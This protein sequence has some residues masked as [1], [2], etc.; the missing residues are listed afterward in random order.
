MGAMEFRDF[1]VLGRFRIWVLGLN[2]LGK[3]YIKVQGVGAL[4]SVVR[5]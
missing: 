3:V 1:G 2:G 4:H 5:E